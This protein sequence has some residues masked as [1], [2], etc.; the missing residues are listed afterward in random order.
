MKDTIDQGPRGV[1]D[2]QIDPDELMGEI[3]SV[4]FL[5]TAG[6]SFFVHL[7]LIV[8]TSIGYVMLCFEHGTV[9]PDREVQRIAK[10]ERQ[11]KLRE[12]REAAH[13][14]LMA[15]QKAKAAKGKGTKGGNGGGNGGGKTPVEKNINRKAT[16]LPTRSGVGLDDIG[17]I[18]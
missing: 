4:S 3:N 13:K 15:D 18:E 8:G 16:T 10:E 6:I 11:R 5:R 1:P 2:G 14:K 9:H 7:V 17:E 12:D